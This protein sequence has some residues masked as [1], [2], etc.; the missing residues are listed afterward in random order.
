MNIAWPMILPLLTDFM[1]SDLTI[2]APEGSASARDLRMAF[3]N[4]RVKVTTD[5]RK[6]KGDLLVA[7]NKDGAFEEEELG[8][9]LEVAREYNV[10]VMHRGHVMTDNVYPGIGRMVYLVNMDEGLLTEQYRIDGKLVNF[11]KCLQTFQVQTKHLPDLRKLFRS[12]TTW[13]STISLLALGSTLSRET[14]SRGGLTSRES[15]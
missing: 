7:L 13:D 8:E 2:V 9:L 15:T 14:S 5:L 11:K 12:G 10:F 1:C 4:L 3:K 6:D